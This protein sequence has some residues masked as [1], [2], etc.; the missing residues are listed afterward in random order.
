MSLAN[1]L[2]PNDYNIYANTF[3]INE[4]DA[5]ELDVETLKVINSSDAT[6]IVTL[7]TNSSTQLST[8]NKGILALGVQFDAAQSSL[9]HYYVDPADYVIALAGG[10]EVGSLTC[11]FTRL[12]QLIFCTVRNFLEFSASALVASVA[13]PSAYR[14]THNIAI[15]LP[16]YAA[17]AIGGN[18]A[19]LYMGYLNSSGILTFSQTVG[20]LGTG[21]EAYY[22]GVGNDSSER[23][24]FSYL[25]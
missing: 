2:Q 16:M 12:G 14:P 11:N 20:E 25:L 15:A 13:I 18:K 10:S 9:N 23:Y 4:I 6:K 21:A 8:G 19:I 24:C 17:G 3:T 5:T 22:V 7:T 1:L